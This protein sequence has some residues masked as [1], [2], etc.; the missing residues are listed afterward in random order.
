MQITFLFTS[1]SIRIHFF[2]IYMLIC[3]YLDIY[4]KQDRNHKESPQRLK[5]T[6]SQFSA[7]GS[8]MKLLFS[9][10]SL[11]LSVNN[12]THIYLSDLRVYFKVEV[13]FKVTWSRMEEYYKYHRKI[14]GLCQHYQRWIYCWPEGFIP[15][16]INLQL[17]ASTCKM[18]K[19]LPEECADWFFD[20]IMTLII[21]LS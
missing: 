16:L 14:S 1:L 10:L 2:P 5:G 6:G 17:F 20:D 7:S 3:K 12:P 21:L 4:S 9:N 11:I 19:W 8:L 15:W 18:I 13:Y